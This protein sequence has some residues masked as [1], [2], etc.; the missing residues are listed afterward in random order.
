[1]F[2][3][4]ASTKHV[5]SNVK[6]TWF[7]IL[8][9]LACSFCLWLRAL[10]KTSFTDHEWI[11]LHLFSENSYQ[12]YPIST[13]LDLLG[14]IFIYP[15]FSNYKPYDVL[16]TCPD[17]NLDF[18]RSSQ[19]FYLTVLTHL[20]SFH[21]LYWHSLILSHHKEIQAPIFLDDLILKLQL[22]E[23]IHLITIPTTTLQCSEVGKQEPLLSK[24]NW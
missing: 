8:G 11:H 22:S 10:T 15:R 3:R 7:Q 9:S 19:K 4:L 20:C 23:S 14:V 21:L 16:Q 2:I 1:M 13:S 24:N 5:A 18:K 17:L 6:S 12:P